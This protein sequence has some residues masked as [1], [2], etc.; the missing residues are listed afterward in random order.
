MDQ[1]FGDTEIEVLKDE[2][3]GKEALPASM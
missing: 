1:G 2:M 3:E